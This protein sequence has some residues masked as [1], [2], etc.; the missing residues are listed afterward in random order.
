MRITEEHLHYL[1]RRL[2]EG[3]PELPAFRQQLRRR[4]V[5]RPHR[6]EGIG[7]HAHVASTRGAGRGKKE[8][9]A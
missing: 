5:H 9:A 3:L 8:R 1:A 4:V 2:D 6:T 7:W